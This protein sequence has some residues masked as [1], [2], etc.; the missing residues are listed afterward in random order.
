MNTSQDIGELAKALAAAQ[1][2][3]PA[4]TRNRE[5]TVKSEKG[6]YKF[7]YATLDHILELTKAARAK[8]GLALSWGCRV[9][10]GGAFV[11]VGRQMHASG[12]WIESWLPLPTGPMKAQEL[13]SAL[14]YRKRYI[15]DQL[16]G[17]SASEDDDANS[18]EGNH[19]EFR[20]RTPRQPPVDAD[21]P[22]SD[23]PIGKAPARAQEAAPAAKA[24]AAKPAAPKL[25]PLRRE[26]LEAMDM[27]A[28]ANE[29]GKRLGIEL[30]KQ[31]I[32]GA[33]GDLKI[34]A[35]AP[36]PFGLGKDAAAGLRE[37]L[38]GQLVGEK[39]EAK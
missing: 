27:K 3:F 31:E 7:E 26:A 15:A 36:E 32:D 21:F 37:T 4:I 8:N 19:A 35:D 39:D 5:V 28:L 6:S 23:G 22:P 25:P 30:T 12:Q 20:G 34:K 33:G 18:E 16:L 14:T 24:P 1:S 17:L 13:G 2:E 29:H 10:E 11:V 38:I 9:V